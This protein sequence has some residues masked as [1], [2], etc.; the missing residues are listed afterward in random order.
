MTVRT[1]SD[2]KSSNQ[3]Y[4]HICV[5][6]FN[7]L[8]CLLLKLLL[9]YI[10]INT[11]KHYLPR[12]LTH[13]PIKLRILAVQNSQTADDGHSKQSNS[14]YTTVVLLLNYCEY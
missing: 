14:I 9:N 2:E 13:I 6:I 7:Q 10:F 1:L 8:F 3:F 5:Q 4:I 12:T 11:F